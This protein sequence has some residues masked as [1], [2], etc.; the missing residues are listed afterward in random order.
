MLPFCRVSWWVLLCPRWG[1]EGHEDL[2]ST[3]HLC[4]RWLSSGNR[5]FWWRWRRRWYIFGENIGLALPSLPLWLPDSTF[6]LLTFFEAF[7]V[8][9][10]AD[11]VNMI[12]CLILAE[13]I[14]LSCS[15]FFGQNAPRCKKTDG[16]RHEVSD[17]ITSIVSCM[18]ESSQ[19]LR[20]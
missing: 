14:F 20:P 17:V 12:S 9:C 10:V 8:E 6:F 19:A 15:D 11:K 4:G 7:F 3:L 16:Q 13:M 1:P 2:Q 5:A 18:S